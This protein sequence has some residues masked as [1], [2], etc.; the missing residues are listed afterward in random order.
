LLALIFHLWYPR[1]ATAPQPSEPLVES[2]PP[3]A[4]A[5]EPL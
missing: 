1:R 3:A 2:S 4:D 5:A